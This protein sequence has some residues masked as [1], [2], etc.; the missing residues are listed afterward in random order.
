MTENGGSIETDEPRRTGPAPGSFLLG[1]LESFGVYAAGFLLLVLAGA[2][3]RNQPGGAGVLV[4]MIV[5]LAFGFSLGLG[6]WHGTQR[7][8][9]TATGV[10]VGTLLWPAVAFGLLVWAFF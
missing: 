1:L 3:T 7:R 8:A 5:L 6:I 4:V 2:A 9:E 10:I